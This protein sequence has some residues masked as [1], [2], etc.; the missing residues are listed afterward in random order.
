[1]VPGRKRLFG[2]VAGVLL[3]A[4]CEPEATPLP[5]NLPTT[6]P[7]LTETASAP[8]NLR[9]AISANDALY[10]SEED[11]R[12]IGQGA[13]LV[14]FDETSTAENP[15]ADYE[16]VVALGSLEDGTEAPDA[17]HISLVLNTALAPLND[18][19]IAQIVY[20]GIDPQAIAAALGLPPEQG[21]AAPTLTR[22]ALRTDL[23]NA[24]YPDGF[25]LT[26]AAEVST[27]ADLVRQ[28]LGAL[29]IDVRVTPSDADSAHL[30]MLNTAATGD[31]ILPL[32]NIPIYY[33]AVEGLNLSFAPSG[34]PV[35]RR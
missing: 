32:L 4:A 10:L 25:D 34:F 29:G 20:L 31:R 24:G 26:L 15:V 30:T 28:Q 6:T 27:V 3:L 8:Q 23:A 33:R 12:L 19:E 1:M 17:L 11:R 7:A 5:V 14:S 35:I 9:Y 18:A 2:I 16:I 13:E 21:G 22:D